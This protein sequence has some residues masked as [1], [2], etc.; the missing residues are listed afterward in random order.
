MMWARAA[1]HDDALLGTVLV[2][3]AG[4][5]F[6]FDF[7]GK[8]VVAA[9]VS[10]GT[11]SD[12]LIELDGVHAW[13][14]LRHRNRRAGAPRLETSGVGTAGLHPERYLAALVRPP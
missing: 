10:S 7:S 1:A 6:L 4:Q 8:G 5:C 2:K 3:V 11:P 12:A 9:R 14:L 13:E